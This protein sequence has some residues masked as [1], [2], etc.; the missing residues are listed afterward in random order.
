MNLTKS[1]Q[2]ALLEALSGEILKAFKG[3]KYKTKSKFMR[4]KIK[5]FIYLGAIKKFSLTRLKL[6]NLCKIGEKI[7][8][9][10]SKSIEC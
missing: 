10:L 3:Q 6:L 2:I 7:N 4:N 5:L 9:W 1:N 8:V